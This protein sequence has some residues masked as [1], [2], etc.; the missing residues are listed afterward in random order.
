[1][2]LEPF[3]GK[4][5]WRKKKIRVFLGEEENVVGLMW[6]IMFSLLILC[7]FFNYL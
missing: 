3:Y 2:P 6:R 5:G 7:A 4:G 1:M